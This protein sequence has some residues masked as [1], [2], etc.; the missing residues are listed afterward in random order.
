MISS[1]LASL[2]VVAMRI[3]IFLCSFYSCLYYLSIPSVYQK[4]QTLRKALSIWLRKQKTCVRIRDKTKAQTATYYIVSTMVTNNSNKETHDCLKGFQFLRNQ[5]NLLQKTKDGIL[6]YFRSP[7]N[8]L[9]INSVYVCLPS[10]YQQA[11][12]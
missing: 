8:I 11:L 7:C 9:G 1:I 10:I 12:R 3:H 4:I 6:M 5:P 2:F